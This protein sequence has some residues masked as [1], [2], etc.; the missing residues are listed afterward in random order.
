MWFPRSL[1]TLP[2][3]SVIALT[4][5]LTSTVQADEASRR[6]IIAEIFEFQQFGKSMVQMADMAGN[7]MIEMFKGQ[8]P[9][10]NAETESKIRAL[11]RENISKLEPGLME[12]VERFMVKHYTDDELREML[13]FY[14]SDVGRKS[15]ELTP[16]L[17]EETMT[18]SQ[19]QTSESM[20]GLVEEITAL[21]DDA[22]DSSHSHP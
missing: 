5:I 16:Q 10:M 3:A 1:K 6:E 2:G 22:K 4:A 9:T 19:Q 18:W 17:M 13:A 11:V 15:I 12:R 7:Q 21:L 20:S 8:F 14:Q